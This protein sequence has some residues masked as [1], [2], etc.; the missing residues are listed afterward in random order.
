MNER[1][2]LKYPLFDMSSV[3][4]DTITITAPQFCASQH[5]AM[6]GA[7]ITLWTLEG[8]QVPMRL[9]TFHVFGT[10]HVIRG[11]L[12]YVGTVHDRS[13]V[14]HVFEQF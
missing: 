9:R 8:D 5:L 6:Q 4:E 7:V 10:G 12:S 3:V 2:M 1:R 14:W 11:D 13:F